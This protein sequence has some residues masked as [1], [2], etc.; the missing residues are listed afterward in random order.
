MNECS[1]N[2]VL[3]YANSKLANVLFSNELARKLEGNANNLH[4][5]KILTFF[6][7]RN[8]ILFFRGQDR[9]VFSSSR[10]RGNKSG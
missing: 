7:S 5:N 9:R 4:K 3:A 1:Y 6:F 2:G 8:K 10:G